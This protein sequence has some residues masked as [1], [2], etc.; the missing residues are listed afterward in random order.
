MDGNQRTRSDLQSFLQGYVGDKVKVYSQ[1][2][3]STKMKYPCV[4]ITY[5]NV[6]DFQADNM[7]YVSHTGYQ[8]TVI[9]YDIDSEVSD[10]IR[11]LPY[12]SFDRFYTAD[13]LNHFVYTLFY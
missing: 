6:N 2:P 8:L 4:R 13:N 9:D 3:P 5:S 10:L 12:C 11:K 1:P 7:H